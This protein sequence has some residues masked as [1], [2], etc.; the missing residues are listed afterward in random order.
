MTITPL[1]TIMFDPLSWM[2]PQRLPLKTGFNGVRQ[3]SIINDMVI[4]AHGWS[5]VPPVLTEKGLMA[6]VIHQWCRLPQIALL[7]AC[8]RH[9]AALTRQG[10]L[11]ILPVWA[12]RFAQMNIVASAAGI[13]PSAWELQTL[14][15]WGEIRTCRLRPILAGSACAA[16]SPVVSTRA[17]PGR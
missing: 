11:L 17:G 13:T 6:R 16:Y 15:S 7:I 2:H 14:L 5:T 9:R 10:R 1:D 8:Q 12:R 4:E 3:R